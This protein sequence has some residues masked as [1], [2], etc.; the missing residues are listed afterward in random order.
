[1]VSAYTR[2]Q[3]WH[4][5]AM[6]EA[7]DSGPQ[8]QWIV[9]DRVLVRAGAAEQ[10]LAIGVR[11]ARIVALAPAAEVRTSGAVSIT[12]FRRRP[13]L[14]AFVNGHVHLAMAPLRG[15]TSRSRR[16]GNVVTDVFFRIEQHLTAP[17]VFAFA[18]LAAFESLLFG[19]GEVWDHYYFGQQVARALAE[20]GLSGVVAPTLQDVG[21]PFAGGSEEQLIA[22]RLIHQDSFLS[23]RGV[24]AAV[25]PHASD[26]VSDRLFEQAAHLAHEL[27]IPVHLHLAQ[28]A[29][30][31]SVEQHVGRAG[32]VA[33]RVGDWLQ[34]CR[35]VMAHGLFFS[36]ADLARLVAARWT[37]A[38][39]PLSQVQFGFLSPVQQWLDL[40]G[41]L[42]VGTDCV[43]SN[44]ALSV[45]RE[46]PWLGAQAAL[47]TSFGEERRA[48]LELGSGARLAQLEESRTRAQGATIVEG[49]ELLAVGLGEGL[50][51]PFSGRLEVGALANIQ[52]LEADAP[53]LFPDGDLARRLAYGETSGA[54]HALI[55]AGRMVGEAGAFRASLIQSAHYREALDEAKRRRV[56]LLARAGID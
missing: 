26:T 28:S 10:A 39:C 17:D 56:E 41:L 6:F 30:E 54:L 49:V 25:G 18:R 31:M 19:V 36:K 7:E 3:L 51:D 14:P 5:C 34:G 21:G 2:Q 38:F 55:V 12:D 33:Q 47:A 15:I 8:L 16:R 29:Q 32:F 9:S 50:P 27:D 4:A 35:V 48:L 1:M 23:A 45:Q 13:L 52:V 22:T 20:V 24:R 42:A 53:E 40:G 44:D 11:G 46:L 37:L 43:A